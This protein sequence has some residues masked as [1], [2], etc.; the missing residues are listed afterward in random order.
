MGRECEKQM[1]LKEP[2][3]VGL[4]MGACLGRKKGALDPD[5]IQMLRS[6]KMGDL[7]G[8]VGKHKLHSRNCGR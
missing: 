8:G 3:A 5:T 2:K 6:L 4:N 1:R 7:N